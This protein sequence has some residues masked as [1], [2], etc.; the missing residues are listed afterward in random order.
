VIALSFAHVPEKIRASKEHNLNRRIALMSFLVVIAVSAVAQMG[1][2]PGPEVKKLDYFVGTWTTDGMIAQGP[3]GGGGKFT[4]TA[5]T[6]WLPGN[7]FLQSKT[8]SQ[9]PPEIGGESKATMI[10]GYDTQQN[11][12]TSDRYSSLGQHE[13]SKGTLSGDTWTWTNTSNYGGMEIQGKMTIKILA[14]TSHTMKY[15]ISMDG[16]NW[17]TFMEGK[18]TKK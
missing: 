2:P 17:M 15:E 18:V 8:D 14:P 9:M 7:F 4:A 1:E 13:S 5:T 6:E 3:W 16:K 10:M 11:T 12:Y